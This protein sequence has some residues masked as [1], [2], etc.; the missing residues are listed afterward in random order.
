ME[1]YKELLSSFSPSNSR[2]T[3]RLCISPVVRAWCWWCQSRE[4]DPCANHSLK[5]WSQWSMW[6]P[7]NSEYFVWFCDSSIRSS[8]PRSRGYIQGWA[9][10]WDWLS[11]PEQCS[12][13]ANCLSAPCAQEMLPTAD[14]APHSPALPEKLVWE[15]AVTTG[16]VNTPASPSAWCDF[17]GTDCSWFL[18]N[19]WILIF[20]DLFVCVLKLLWGLHILIHLWHFQVICIYLY[21][22]NYTKR[23]CGL[24]ARNHLEKVNGLL[25]VAVRWGGRD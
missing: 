7:C 1:Y 16:K 22:P 19:L 10:M 8:S 9:P 15:S 14:C 4:L 18:N 21:V 11:S 12:S 20:T 3:T 6:V 17:M 2:G 5:S 13:S 24:L 25:S 23:N